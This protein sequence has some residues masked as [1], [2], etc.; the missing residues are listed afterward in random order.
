[1]ADSFPPKL[2]LIEKVDLISAQLS[3]VAAGIYA[4]ITGPFRG[5]AGAR[6]YGKHISYAVIR[7]MLLRISVRQ[8]QYDP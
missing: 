2:S 6:D 1:M 7:K 8:N 3:I 4:A 5:K